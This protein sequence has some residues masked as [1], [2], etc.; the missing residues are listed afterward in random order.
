[1]L[2]DKEYLLKT[3][4][5]YRRTISSHLNMISMEVTVPETLGRYGVLLEMSRSAVLQNN[6]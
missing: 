1:M 2:E 4:L 3:A 5:L 6:V